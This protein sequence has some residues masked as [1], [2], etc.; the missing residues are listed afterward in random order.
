MLLTSKGLNS[1]TQAQQE[2]RVARQQRMCAWH[3]GK[4]EAENMEAGLVSAGG[5]RRRSEI[6][7]KV[8]VKSFLT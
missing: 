6:G 5:T 2:S 1:Q 4:K 8:G 7:S 3:R